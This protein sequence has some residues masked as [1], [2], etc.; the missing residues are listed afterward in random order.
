MSKNIF[1]IPTNNSL[2]KLQLDR[3]NEILT[4]YE[5]PC[6]RNSQDY[7]GTNIYITSDEEIKEG[8]YVIALDSNVFFKCNKHEAEKPIKQF[9]SIYKKIILTTDQDLIADGVQTIDDEFLECFVKNPSCERINILINSW[10][11]Y[12]ANQ[13]LIK[14][15]YCKYKIIIPQEE[16]KTETV[17]EFA[18]RLCDIPK[19]LSGDKYKWSAHDRLLYNFILE[20]AK[21]QSERMYSEEEVKKLCSKAWLKT[22]NTSNMLEEFDF[23]FEQ[24]KKEVI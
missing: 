23:W 8:D 5:E 11:K 1:L 17:E 21:W 12:T 10:E 13:S 6:I 16:P 19:K 24:V 22:P 9:K 14:P 20:G 2:A 15:K 3:D 18:E 7:I 4:I